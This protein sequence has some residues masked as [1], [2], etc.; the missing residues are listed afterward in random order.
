MS[1][2][3]E[4]LS[5]L[6]LLIQ[7]HNW[8]ASWASQ[9]SPLHNFDSWFP[10]SKPAL[11]VASPIS[12]NGS[13]TLPYSQT[14]NIYH[15]IPHFPSLI[16]QQNRGFHLQRPAIQNQVISCCLHIWFWSEPRLDPRLVKRRASN[17]ASCFLSCALF[18]CFLSTAARG[19]PLKLLLCLGSPKVLPS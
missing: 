4:F 1:S 18:I 17:P 16:H 13:F 3:P 8:D 11:P 12:A 15:P 14:R 10:P 6:L 2:S 19:V 7:N 5:E 9:T